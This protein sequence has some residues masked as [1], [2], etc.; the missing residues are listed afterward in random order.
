[1]F[2]LRVKGGLLGS[3]FNGAEG[4]AEHGVMTKSKVRG[5]EKT[6]PKS[7]SSRCYHASHLVDSTILVTPLIMFA[8][9][10]LDSVILFAIMF[11]SLQPVAGAKRRLIHFCVDINIVVGRGMS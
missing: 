3:D 11:G 2:F 6:K 7:T 9:Q 1:M 8:L 10:F 4:P 5:G